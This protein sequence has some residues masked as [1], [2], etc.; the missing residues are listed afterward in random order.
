MGVLENR[1]KRAYV[2]EPVQKFN[3]RKER[4]TSGGVPECQ[5][6]GNQYISEKGNQI[7]AFHGTV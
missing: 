7:P 4:Q 6:Y 2:P 5:M 1:R 3:H